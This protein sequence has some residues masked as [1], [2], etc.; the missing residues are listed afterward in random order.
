M[1]NCFISLFLV[2]DISLVCRDSRLILEKRDL[3]LYVN[4]GDVE[5]NSW[6]FDATS[7]GYWLLSSMLSCQNATGIKIIIYPMHCETENRAWYNMEKI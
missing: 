4:V 3:I 7:E 2:T 6:R 5:I 1:L